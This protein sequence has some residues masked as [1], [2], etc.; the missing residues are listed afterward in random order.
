M[1]CILIIDDDQEVR[2]K[3]K[4]LLENEGFNTI[5]ANG[6]IEAI[7][8]L[9]K[10]TPD[11]IV[12]EATMSDMDGYQILNHLQK[13]PAYCTIPFIFL[14][15]RTNPADIRE[16]MNKGAADY[17]TKPFRAKELLSAISAQLKKKD[18][19]DQRLKDA[20]YSASKTQ[21]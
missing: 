20:Y 6:G 19:Y 4:D 13:Q 14:S 16:G 2:D 7:N 1:K 12:S 8:A 11:L 10:G 21:N 3:I 15:S 17:L 18:K 5:I 9:L